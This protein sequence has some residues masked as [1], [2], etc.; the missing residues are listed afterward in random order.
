[1]VK[2]EIKMKE[3]LLLNR[4]FGAIKKIEI[5]Y[6]MLLKKS[7]IQRMADLSDIESIPYEFT[8]QCKH[9]A[10]EFECRR[11]QAI[12]DAQKMHNLRMI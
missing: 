12:A 3:R 6:R 4:Q 1:M 10:H 8:Q 9:D 2:M 5:M 11:A 7:Y